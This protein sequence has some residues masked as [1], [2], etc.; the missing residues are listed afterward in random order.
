MN[1]MKQPKTPPKNLGGTIPSRKNTP[2]ENDIADVYV[3]GEPKQLLHP[4]EQKSYWPTIRK[5]SAVGAICGIIYIAYTI[6]TNV[7][8][9]LSKIEYTNTPS[10]INSTGA[11]GNVLGTL[12]LM[13]LVLIC[14]VVFSIVS[15]GTDFP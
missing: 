11:M 5:V 15:K 12:P 3:L 2:H 8:V 1:S 10:S 13:T 4:K 7:A 9:G 6:T 14:A